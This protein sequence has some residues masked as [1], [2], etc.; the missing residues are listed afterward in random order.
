MCVYVHLLVREYGTEESSFYDMTGKSACESVYVVCVSVC[1]S[2]CV[3]SSRRF[4][5]LLLLREKSER[6]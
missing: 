5:V 1:V 4:C 2:L 3:L 6:I